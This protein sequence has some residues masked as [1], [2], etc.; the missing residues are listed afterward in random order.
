MEEENQ[1][2]NQEIMEWQTIK[3]EARPKIRYWLPSAAV[4][5]DDLRH[6]LEDLKRRGFGGVEIVTLSSIPMEIATGE[7]GWGTQHWNDTVEFI[8]A[9]TRELGMSLDIANGPGWPIA[10]PS[11]HHADDPAA[12]RELT[13]GVTVCDQGGHYHG[14]IPGRRV[15]HDEGTSALL[16]VMAYLET[17]PKVLRQSSY[18][19]L[20]GSLNEEQTE[21]DCM[22]PDLHEG[23]RWLIFAFYVQPSVQKSGNGQ[24]YVIDHL[25]K[26]GAQA[27][28]QYWDQI[29]AQS[30]RYAS[31]ESIFCD[32]LEYQVMMEWTMGFDT[33]FE[34]EMGYSILPYLPIIKKTVFYPETD[35]P[36]YVFEGTV[37]TDQ[38]NN[39]YFEMLTR[40]YC[41]NHLQELER[42]AEKH[43]KTV[44][45]QVAY[46]KP[47]EGE[48]CPLYVGIPENEALGRPA[49]D[50]QKFMAAAA[51]LGR[52]K[53]YSF[54]CAAIF[55]NA[56]GQ[57]YDDL[58]WWV[59][60]GL[61]AGMNAQVLHGASYSGSYHGKYAVNGAMEGVQ[62]PGY[63]GFGKA[64]SNYW[65]RTLSVEDA[66]GVLDAI[67]R[68]NTLF[69]H[70]AKVD[71]AIYRQSYYNDGLGSEFCL[72]QDHGALANRGYTYEFISPY[73]L[74]HP[75][76]RVTNGILDEKGA[77]YKALIIP[78]Q[79]EISVK[80]LQQLER[81]L[82]DRFP[83]FWV[84][85]RPVYSIYYHEWNDADRRQEWNDYLDRIWN[86]PCMIHVADIEQV[87]DY[88]RQEGILPNVG[89]AGTKDIMTAMHVDE[90]AHKK[91][92]ALYAYNRVVYSPDDPNPDEILCSGLYKKG[93]T[94]GS[95]KRAGRQSRETVQVRIA[96]VGTVYKW[97]YWTGRAERLAFERQGNAMCGRVTIEEDEMIIL[98]LDENQVEAIPCDLPQNL[99]NQPYEIP[100]TF[101][102]LVLHE[103]G[104]AT[105]AE[106][107]FLRSAYRTEP[108][109][110]E[111]DVLGPWRTLDP[112]LRKFAGKGIYT[113]N[114]TLAQWRPDKNYVLYLGNVQDTFHVW[115]NDELVPGADQVLKKV[116]ITEFLHE[117][118]NAI[119][120][121]VVS[122]L[123]NRLQ[124]T[125]GKDVV[126]FQVP[127][128]E[129]DYGIWEDG[130]DRCVVRAE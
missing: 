54:E 59:K 17:G 94:K 7:D 11:I 113:G 13:Y 63:E 102:N 116:N 72:Y 97:N 20:M 45:Y 9:V 96:G 32:S 22:L 128:V 89:L 98:T 62:W 129:K 78:E 37:T 93:T 28:E 50:F 74:D 30:D 3:N 119:K 95:Y 88:L 10:M 87:P 105:P 68:L 115:I 51:H 76:A 121:E 103:F 21:I 67:A 56:Y 69:L 33:L 85:P 71:C 27:C 41:E 36:G 79:R 43:G 109:C 112:T 70:K 80:F 100:V 40:C 26:A 114:I 84:G 25:S 81:L 127:Y 82:E 91:Y 16:H 4:D 6:E 31:M 99:E 58:F 39:D 106:K 86:H 126:P 125:G 61:I 1:M 47:F 118:E 110:Y 12:L 49:I 104:P 130:E 101:H 52:K 123:Y 65:N 83:V 8:A 124:G 34:Q 38:I 46:N 77:G 57:T 18:R 64:I 108:R 107:S 60:R 2:N 73:L 35:I 90:E 55:G 92:C 111:G 122:N 5:H 42:I 15:V 117:G 53:R 24:Y 19:D 44:R 120:V 14:E 48:R 23:E 29:L 66:R 75:A